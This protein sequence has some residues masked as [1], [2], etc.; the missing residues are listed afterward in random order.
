MANTEIHF[1]AITS[2]KYNIQALLFA[3]KPFSNIE[4]RPPLKL[5][6]SILDTS[7]KNNEAIQK[8][9][10]K[11]EKFLWGFIL[12]ELFVITLTFCALVYFV[13]KNFIEKNRPPK[14]EI[15]KNLT[16]PKLSDEI[17]LINRKKRRLS[18]SDV[19]TNND[20]PVNTATPGVND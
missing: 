14:T 16:I 4:E 6:L 13:D 5:L 2:D 11:T 12:C 15:M 19:P 1:S 10:D 8:Q 18:D 3:K 7:V 17:F 9:A 20:E